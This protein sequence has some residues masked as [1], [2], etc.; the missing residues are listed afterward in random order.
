M[1]S[2]SIRILNF[3]DS[4]IKQKNLVSRYHT[5][6]IDLKDLG[7]RARI[8]LDKKTKKEIEKRING[9]AKN[10]ITFLG[11]GDFHQ[12]SHILINQFGEPISLI[13]FDFHP[14]W[15]IFPPPPGLRFLGD[16]EF[17]KQEYFKAYPRRAFFQRSVESLDSDG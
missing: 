14:D 6:I 3:D 4:I 17:E 1:L 8:W 7:P 5:E 12:V 2:Q 9:S 11:S 13:L 10:S 15:D 16:R